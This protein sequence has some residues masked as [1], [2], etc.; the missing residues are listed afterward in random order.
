[1]H[2]RFI[3]GEKSNVGRTRRYIITV[4]GTHRSHV[5]SGG[6]TVDISHAAQGGPA[7][8]IN[9]IL[10]IYRY[11]KREFKFRLRSGSTI[12][13]ITHLASSSKNFPVPG[14]LFLQ[15]LWLKASGT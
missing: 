9:T 14:R 10:T 8:D 2:S 13:R 12:T 3:R 15:T 5:A 1:M 7:G 4:L 11:S 6:V